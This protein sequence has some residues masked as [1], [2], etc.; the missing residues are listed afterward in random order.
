M[1]NKSQLATGL[2]DIN[3]TVQLPT[4]INHN[5]YSND[6]AGFFLVVE[7][8]ALSTSQS[9]SFSEVT[10]YGDNP[11]W[12]VAVG[13]DT[14]TWNVTTH[15]GHVTRDGSPST[16][17]F[18][19]AELAAM[20]SVSDEDVWTS[21]KA[22][23]T[24]SGLTPWL[25]I[26]EL[27]DA[28]G[29]NSIGHNTIETAAE[30]V[31]LT[32]LLNLTGAAHN[33]YST[34][35]PVDGSTTPYALQTTVVDDYVWNKESHSGHTTRAEKGITVDKS[36]VT[37]LLLAPTFVSA[38]T[39]TDGTKTVLT[40]NETLSSATAVASDFDV[41]TDGAANPV[42][43]VAISGATVEL[44]LTNTV[45]NDHTVTVAY[46]DP[47]TGNDA[48][49]IQ[50][51]FGTDAA[52]LSSTAVTNNSTVAG[53]APTFTSAATSTDG[54]KVVLTYNET[55]SA[56]TAE[57]SAFAITTDS[58]AN[59]VTA[60]AISGSTV[61]LT[62]TNTVKNDQ[63]VTV[64]YTDPS[65]SNDSNTIQDSAGNDAESLTSSSVT[66]NSS[67]AGTT[68]T[69]TSAATSTDGTKVVLT[70]DETLSATTA[71]TSA[72]AI[73]SDGTANAVTAVAISGSTVELT[74][75]NTVKNDQAVTVAYTDPTT[76]N[77][78]N[79]I[80][81]SAGNDAASLRST[82]LTNNSI[83]VS[84]TPTPEQT[85]EPT[86]ETN[87]TANDIAAL[88]TK[89]ITALTKKQLK[90]LTPDACNGFS[91]KQ[92][93]Q[94][95]PDACNGFSKK[96]IAAIK[97]LAVG[98][99]SSEQINEL[100]TRSFT[101]LSKNQLSKLTK[102]AITGL[103]TKH[104]KTISGNE[105]SVI[106][107]RKIKA[108]DPDVIS[109]LKPATLDEFSN[110][111]IKALTNKQLKGLSKKQIRKSEDFIDALSDKQNSVL[112]KSTQ[113]KS[114]SAAFMADQTSTPNPIEIISVTD[115]LA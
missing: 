51:G 35:D 12:T 95:T 37:D 112:F 20:R 98:G 55:L 110:R 39:T 103:T 58:A 109:G 72:F 79:A 40:Y 105:I 49:A 71:A 7:L 44:T 8:Y 66:N 59:P 47:T 6:A 60:V 75:T 50:D 45:K 115:P 24:Q 30:F 100:K 34:L 85:S 62:L 84:P 3:G 52:S 65:N 19:T 81:D 38:A 78:A 101:G 96:Q 17:L 73:T 41:I 99:F 28:N 21:L 89:A 13:D 27:V 25:K 10:G 113:T 9:T 108:I 15:S 31:V 107:H 93:K 82:A 92:L 97:P 114:I 16:E 102:D 90:Q 14:F 68:P 4:S 80:Q 76:G 33:S 22:I 61:E 63:A 11:G 111:Q 32:T 106:H 54:T 77:D 46:T 91:K 56:T 29:D 42:T 26:A 69:F 18:T 57:T 83:V 67:V 43:A 88:K 64:G 86:P 87:L 104:L 1:T 5:S 48:N 70:Y 53:T 74:L 36:E 94:L 2:V 23:N